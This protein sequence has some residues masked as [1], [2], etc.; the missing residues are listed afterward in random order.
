MGKGRPP[1]VHRY[2]ASEIP[3]GDHMQFRQITARPSSPVVGNEMLDEDKIVPGNNGLMMILF[4]QDGTRVGKTES[5]SFSV[6]EGINK[7]NV[8]VSNEGLADGQYYYEISIIQRNRAFAREK[9]DCIPNAIPFT[10]CNTEVF[11]I[12]GEKWQTSYYGH[13][14]MKPIQIVKRDE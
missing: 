13:I 2:I 14:M 6:H 3:S 12:K 11:G 4:Y 1:G 7:V 10:I 9:C 5:N 8:L